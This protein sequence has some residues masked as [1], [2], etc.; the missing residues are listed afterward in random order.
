M[1][2]LPR[3]S[4]GSPQIK[5]GSIQKV[6]I[7]RRT[8]AALRGARGP[9][10]PM[11]ATGATGATGPGGAPGPAGPPGPPG[12]SGY[13]GGTSPDSTVS[14]PAGAQG[15]AVNWCPAGTQPLG[16]GYSS[17]TVG[18]SALRTVSAGF[19]INDVTG[20]PGFR[21]TMANGGVAAE[22]F[23]VQVRCASVS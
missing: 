7:S 20:A 17:Q 5:N 14:V 4:V 12:L 15:T 6:D 2:A 1:Q 22:S 16:G 3:N 21:V 23:H 8:V 11:G 13:V 19:F 18:D 9:A 10:G